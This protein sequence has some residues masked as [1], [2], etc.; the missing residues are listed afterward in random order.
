MEITM[1]YSIKVDIF[2]KN[3]WQ[4]IIKMFDDANIYQT[5]SYGLIKYGRKNISHLV[6]EKN[7]SIVAATQVRIVKIPFINAGIAYVRWG[8]LWQSTS[9]RNNIEVFRQAIRALYNEYVFHR[10]MILRL[11]PILFNND[12]DVF[13][14]ILK[15]E[16]FE[17]V[18]KLRNEKTLLIDL[19]PSLEDLRKGLKQ[20]WR[21]CLNSAEKSGLQVIEGYDDKLFEIFIRIYRDMLDRKKFVPTSDINEFRLIQQYLPDDLKMKV[22]ICRSNTDFL[23]GAI[24][25]VI[26]KTGIYLFGATSKVGM[27]SKG[28]Y[29]IQWK[30]IKWLKEKNCF[31]YDLH[32]INPIVNPGT[33]KF[34]VGLSGTNGKEVQFLGQFNAYKNPLSLCFLKYAEILKASYQKTRVMINNMQLYRK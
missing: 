10:G 33:Y 7:G 20:K 26:G 11:F 29:L 2:N 12:S 19:I 15:E 32:G 34:K 22:F 3:T 23:A 9:I 4:N 1:D 8:P 18:S 16:G 13:L 28:S 5:W 25:S 24:C 17:R 14:S 21:N 30:I 31:F 6:F 27:K